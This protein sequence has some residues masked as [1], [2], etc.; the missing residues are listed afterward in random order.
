MFLDSGMTGIEFSIT[1]DTNYATSGGE[2]SLGLATDTLFPNKVKGWFITKHP[3]LTNYVL[4]PELVR[5]TNDN[6]TNVAIKLFRTYL[7]SSTNNLVK[8]VEC[9]NT[10]DLSNTTMRAILYGS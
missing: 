8:H 1:F 2:S 7:T 3:R 9:S 6:P 4:V 5:G 10:N